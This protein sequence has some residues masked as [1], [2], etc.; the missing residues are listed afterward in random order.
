MFFVRIRVRTDCLPVEAY[1]VFFAC[2]FVNTCC[3]TYLFYYFCP[4]I[5]RDKDNAKEELLF[6]VSS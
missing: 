3:G 6:G 1:F 4:E 2:F 5:K